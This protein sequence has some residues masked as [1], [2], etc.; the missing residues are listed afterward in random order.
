V[1]QVIFD[2]R[3]NS[4][5]DSSVFTGMFAGCAQR[6]LIGRLAGLRRIVV[7]ACRETISSGMLNALTLAANGAIVVGRFRDVGEVNTAIG[8]MPGALSGLPAGR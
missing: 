4:G 7:I 8:H 5:D 6:A 2:L 3:N 1:E